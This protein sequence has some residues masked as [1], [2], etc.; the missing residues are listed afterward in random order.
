MTH[1]QQQFNRKNAPSPP[2]TALNNKKKGRGNK[3]Q[4]S[5]PLLAPTPPEPKKKNPLLDE[6]V[7]IEIPEDVPITCL[8][9]NMGAFPDRVQMIQRFVLWG[10]MLEEDFERNDVA[11]EM[12]KLE[13]ILAAELWL[14]QVWQ[15]GGGLLIPGEILI[16]IIPETEIQRVI[17]STKKYSLPDGVGEETWGEGDDIP[18]GDSPALTRMQQV[19][20]QVGK[21]SYPLM[22]C[23]YVG[24]RRH[25]LLVEI[26]GICGEPI[27][28]TWQQAVPL[29]DSWKKL[30]RNGEPKDVEELVAEEKQKGRYSRKEKGLKRVVT[31]NKLALEPTVL[32]LSA[33]AS[34]E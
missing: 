31:N 18:Y 22:F 9:T 10:R 32:S 23:R 5:G 17:E 29:P 1:E 19:G 11:E 20:K 21:S 28:L 3:E 13:K 6:E 7:T 34:R 16:G 33:Y 15:E 2:P 8:N 25:G 26:G 4:N 14:E 30:V 27:F 12:E 24:T